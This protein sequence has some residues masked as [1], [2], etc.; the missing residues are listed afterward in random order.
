MDEKNKNQMIDIK[1]LAFVA[2][3]NI[4]LI[5]LLAFVGYVLS[6]VY[7]KS[8]EVPTYTSSVSLYVK[9][10]TNKATADSVSAGDLSAAKTIAST[11][12]AVLEDDVVMETIGSK[13]LEK[14]GADKVGQYLVLEADGDTV[15]INTD[16]IRN[17][18]TI[19]QVNKT[20][21]LKISAT[22]PSA[23][24]SADICTFITEYAPEQLRR[25]VGAGSVENVG[26][27]KVPRY[28]DGSKV[29]ATARNG[30]I[31]GIILAL[32]IIYIR[33][34]L[35]NTV[36][37]GESIKAK[38][39]LPMLA[40]VPFYDVEGNGKTKQ[41]NNL[42]NRI[43]F[44][45]NKDKQ[46]ER[47]VRSTIADVNVPFI[48][49]E[50]Y[51]T[52][53]TNIMFAFSTNDS[54][55]N[56]AVISSSLAGEGKSTSSANLAI[57]M[58]STESKVLLVDADIR[59]PTQHRMFNL[60]NDKGLSTILS[61]MSKLE[62]TIHKNVNGN[63]DI[64]TAGPMPPNPSQMLT[65]EYMRNFMN[66]VSKMYDYVLVDTSP[67]NIVSDALI[68]SRDTAGVVL[69]TRAGITTYDQIDRA[70]D[71]IQFAGANVLGVIINASN[72]ESGTYK[73]GY[74]KKYKYNYK[75]NYIIIIGRTVQ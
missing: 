48:V 25:V 1:E 43:K 57:S 37:G 10:T 30:L 31:L 47:Q 24:I 32:L 41:K 46:I 2:L 33:Y 58:G 5:I 23:E 18:I 72:F 29:P 9:N 36:T 34:M 35:D 22:T 20:E 49:T 26:R 63:L 15:N 51:N 66:E 27:I 39:D 12:I 54:K 21:L 64:I 4:W 71:S 6:Y 17:C 65:S 3:R 14:Y 8:T 53:R 67:I 60:K 42:I 74:S 75:Y 19:E 44:K 68:L 16:S 28:S 50:A 62:D 61:G 38:Y 45:L 52:L 69:V 11:Y 7:A 55:S 40:E 13:L 73:K 56:I 59:K 70:I